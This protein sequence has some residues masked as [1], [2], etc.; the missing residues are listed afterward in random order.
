MCV[1]ACDRLFLL[2]PESGRRSDD[3]GLKG[4]I[5]THNDPILLCFI[6]HLSEHFFIIVRPA[7]LFFSNYKASGND[8]N[9]KLYKKVDL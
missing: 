8:N 5:A 1:R 9:Q 3:A 2:V 6:I 7:D 4:A